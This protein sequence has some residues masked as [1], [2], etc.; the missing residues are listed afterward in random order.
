MP[1]IL[2]AAVFILGFSASGNSAETVLFKED[3]QAG[4]RKAWKPVEFSGQTSYRIKEDGQN[5]YL[6]GTAKSSAT[7]L[8]AE[9]K[10]VA[11]S[12]TQLSWKWKIDK[13]PEGGSEDTK[14]TFDHTARLFVAFKSRIGPPRTINYV[15]ANELSVGKK[16]NHPSS[17]RSRFIVLQSG[18]GKSGQW[19]QEKRD[20]LQDWRTL[21]GDDDPPS[22]VG[23]GFMTDSD[24]TKTTVVGGYDDIVLSRASP[25]K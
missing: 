12:G 20:I 8:A 14:K 1:G 18:N 15:W 4:I 10:N 2:W 21:F 5:A 3:F 17:G 9:L 16:F 11:P 13:V 7:G 6:E 23:I 19:I 25:R 24:G 22:I